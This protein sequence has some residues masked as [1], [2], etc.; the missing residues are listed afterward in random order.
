[1]TLKLGDLINELNTLGVSVDTYPIGNGQQMQ[2][3]CQQIS[4]ATKGKMTSFDP[5][6]DNLAGE[7][8]ATITKCIGMKK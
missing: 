1:M 5:D 4:D 7:I 8:E 3:T 2:K 6:K